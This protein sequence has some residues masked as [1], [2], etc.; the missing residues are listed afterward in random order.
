MENTVYDTLEE[1]L[2]A[3][4]NGGLKEENIGRQ[5]GYLTDTSIKFDSDEVMP[6]LSKKGEVQTN[7][8]N[9]KID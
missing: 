9:K 6:Y 3:I 5:I 7:S 8:S 1:Y 2:T 4:D